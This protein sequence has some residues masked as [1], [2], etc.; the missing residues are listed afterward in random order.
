[1]KLSEPTGGYRLAWLRWRNSHQPANQ[2][3]HTVPYQRGLVSSLFDSTV[4]ALFVSYAH[5]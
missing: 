5:F 1:M 4:S 2:N 3:E